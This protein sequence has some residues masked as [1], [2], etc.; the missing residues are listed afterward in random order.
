MA[1]S[2]T[3]LRDRPRRTKFVDVPV[4]HRD[5]RDD[6]LAEHVQGV[7]GMRVASIAACRICSNGD[8]GGEQIAAV[9]GEEH[10]LADRIQP[11]SGAPETLQA[12]GDRRGHP[13][14]TIRSMLPMSMPNSRLLVATTAGSPRLQVVLDPR[15]FGF[16][17]RAVMARATMV[18]GFWATPQWPSSRAGTS[19]EA[20]LIGGQFVQT[21]GHAL[22]DPPG[23]GEHDRRRAF[24]PG[25]GSSSPPPARSMPAGLAFGRFGE[26]RHVGQGTRSCRSMS[27]VVGR[28]D[29]HVMAGMQV[30]GDRRLQRCDRCRQA[31]A[32]RRVVGQKIQTLQGQAQMRAAFAARHRVD[33]I[34]DHRL[35]HRTRKPRLRCQQ[36]EQDS[37]VVI[38]MSGGLRAMRAFG[39]RVSAVRIGGADHAAWK[40][41][42]GGD[43]FDP[44]QWRAQVTLHVGGQ[45]RSGEM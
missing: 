40:A 19:S 24:P 4:G 9:G 15:P 14:C 28:H 29:P 11:V 6:L 2:R 32:L 43:P 37:G 5:H 44:D 17:H 3:R 31:D 22:A 45:A 41:R 10:A 21:A 34:D 26:R 13:T 35:R 8:R 7:P 39:R 42:R 38:R 20:L 16:A 1:G 12:G 23:V 25:P 36:K 18:A 33:L 30:L 27:L